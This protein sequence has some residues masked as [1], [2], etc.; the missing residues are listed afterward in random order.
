MMVGQ[1]IYHYKII[2]KLGEGG[3]GVVYKAHDTKL[4]RIVALKFLPTAGGE[5]EKARLI[6][7]AQAIAQLDHPNIC[8]VHEIGDSEG[9][10][11]IAMAYIEGETL[12]D[13]VGN[14]PLVMNEIIDYTRQI[15]RGLQSAHRKHITHRDIKSANIMITPD[16]QI[17]IMDFGLAKLAGRTQLTQEGST[18]GTVMYMSP[19]QARGEDVDHRTDIWS[20]GV[21]LYEMLTGRLPFQSEYE[22]AAVYSIL[23]EDPPPIGNFNPD[24]PPELEAI[25]KKALQKNKEDRYQQL[26]ELL[27]DLDVLSGTAVK[28]IVWR[29]VLTG[30][31]PFIYAASL[32]LILLVVVAVFFLGGPVPEA[33][34]IESIAVL[35][36]TNLSN[37]PDQE[38]FSDGMMEEILDRLF[39]IGDLKVISRTSSMRYRNT[40]KSIKEIARELGVGAILGGS[41]RRSGNNV[42]ITVQLINA[43]TD[44]HLW[45]EIYDGDLSDL[46]RIFFIQSEVA[47]SVARELKAVLSPQ[48]VELIENIPT[49]DLAAYDAYLKGKFYN[50]KLTKEGMD[51][52]MQLFELAK[53]RDPDFALA[54]VGIHNVWICRQQMGIAKVSEASPLSEAALTKALELDSTLL[55]QGIGAARMVW[56]DW[57]WEG[58]EKAFRKAI[59]NNAGGH[60]NFSHLLNILGRPDEAMEHIEIALELDPLNPMVW[61]FYAIDLVF[62]RRFDEAIKAAKEAL[63]IEPKAPVAFRAMIYA[64]HM[65]GRYEEAWE[66]IK[67]DLKNRLP[68][69]AQA[70]DLDFDELGYER[71]LKQA[72]EALKTASE[73]TNINPT[74]IADVYVFA[75]DTDNAIYWL[76]KAY[77]EHDPNLPYLLNP[78]YDILRDEPRF[79]EIARKMNLPYK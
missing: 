7:E 34:A 18:A 65:T 12:R 22:T 79:R 15:A 3:M 6:R 14:G 23:N 17:K 49:T 45:S 16:G 35:P 50:R 26:D 63:R 54:Y 10:P 76:E 19:E 40:D 2:E 11:Y 32:L 42:R 20:F 5:K 9:V 60:M 61:S 66:S 56:T 39:K 25:V 72:A 75:G 64:L 28:K 69:Q 59:E 41:V 37:D 73:S 44:A 78:V 53:E 52:A 70:F 68:D 36:F 4:D 43:K 24:V 58:G 62:A 1:T 67:S 27:S 74:S 21:V 71:A 31:K 51:I 55:D 13:R 48:E 8:T 57:D 46:S 30:R 29:R 47:Q 38:Y 33:R 77:E